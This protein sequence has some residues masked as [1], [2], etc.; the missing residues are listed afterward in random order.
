VVSINHFAS[1]TEAEHALIRQRLAS[2]GVTAH[3]ARHWAE[4]GR[5]AVDLARDVVRLAQSG[6]ELR[7]A[8]ADADSLWEKLRLLATRTY[9]ASA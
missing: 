1:D 5:G 3:T 7:F 6:A 4:G 9:G 2:Q 8:Y